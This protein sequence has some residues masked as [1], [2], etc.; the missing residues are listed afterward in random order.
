MSDDIISINNYDSS[1]K[2]FKSIPYHGW[3]KP[4]FYKNCRIVSSHFTVITYKK[5]KFKVYL[6][7]KCHNRCRYYIDNELYDYINFTY[8]TC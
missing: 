7:K 6:C 2:E 4:C 3:I 8:F 1:S 5:T